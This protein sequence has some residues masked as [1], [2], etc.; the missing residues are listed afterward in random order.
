[1]YM[2][3]HVYFWI[4]CVINGII[5]FSKVTIYY[6]LRRPFILPRLRQLSQVRQLKDVVKCNLFPSA[7][8]ILSM[9]KEYGTNAEQWEQK[10]GAN[11]EA[12][13]PILYVRM[14][15]AAA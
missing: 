14:K 15:T 13:M 3:G 7:D 5:E 11:T 1:M 12:D 8:M 10:A 6:I 9:S 4:K 2:R